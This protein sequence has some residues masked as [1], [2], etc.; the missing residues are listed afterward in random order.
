MMYERHLE[1]L[2]KTKSVVSVQIDEL[3]SKVGRGCG[4]EEDKNTMSPPKSDEESKDWITTS[5]PVL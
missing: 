1:A 5:S 4:R 3:G 2:T